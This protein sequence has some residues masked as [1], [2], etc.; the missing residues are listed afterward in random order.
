MF[1]HFAQGADAR[2]HEG[3][4]VAGGLCVV[5]VGP[6]HGIDALPRRGD[7]IALCSKELLRTNKNT[8]T[9]TF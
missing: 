8:F 6:D 3:L 7:S 5:G 4:N 1:G 9:A 2:L